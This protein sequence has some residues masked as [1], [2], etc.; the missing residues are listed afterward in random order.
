MTTY[1]W[2]HVTP[3]LL[4]GLLRITLCFLAAG[5]WCLSCQWAAAWLLLSL[6]AV[7]QCSQVEPVNK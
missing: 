6:L 2:Y 4:F 1:D 7:V 5:L 3:I